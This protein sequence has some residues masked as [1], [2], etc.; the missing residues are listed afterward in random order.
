MAFK[1]TKSHT[2]Q[3]YRNVCDNFIK[4]YEWMH[5]WKTVKKIQRHSAICVLGKSN[6]LDRLYVFTRRKK[7]LYIRKWKEMAKD[8]IQQVCRIA[9]KK[10]NW[11]SVSHDF[12]LR[13]MIK[14]LYRPLKNKFHRVSSSAVKYC[15]CW[16]CFH[17]P[18]LFLLNLS[19]V[20]IPTNVFNAVVIDSAF[21]KVFCN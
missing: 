8:I 10:Q 5:S 17:F 19:T 16:G 20:W 2:S 1:I 18:L 3:K 13:L 15:R 4:K 12:S 9:E 11:A 21:N 6:W 14:A 7:K